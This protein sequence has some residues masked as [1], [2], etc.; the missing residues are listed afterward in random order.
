[1]KLDVISNLPQTCQDSIKISVLQVRKWSHREAVYLAKVIQLR[2]ARAQPPWTKSP[3]SLHDVLLHPFTTHAT[4]IRVLGI[5]SLSPGER[6]AA[7]LVIP[8]GNAPPVRAGLIGAGGNEGCLWVCGEL[9]G[10]TF[11]RVIGHRSLGRWPRKGGWL[12]SLL[13]KGKQM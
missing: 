9:V 5:N 4:A 11:G 1:M 7:I 2:V 13:K 3:S 10:G 8:P 6:A 12:N